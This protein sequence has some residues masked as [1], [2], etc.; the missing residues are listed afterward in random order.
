MDR[1]VRNQQ[2]QA[3]AVVGDLLVHA[4]WEPF[5]DC[6]KR[7][8]GIHGN[9]GWRVGQWCPENVGTWNSLDFLKTHCLRTHWITFVIEM[10][11]RTFPSKKSFKKQHG[12]WSLPRWLAGLH[13]ADRWKSY[14]FLTGAKPASGKV[15]TG[16]NSDVCDEC[17]L[18]RPKNQFS[19]IPHHV[20][21]WE[22]GCL[23][24]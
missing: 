2:G 22:K 21:I 6:R 1:F 8:T 7:P 9:R 4:Q 20:P 17:W 23:N 3:V 14:N 11:F 13:R 12:S 24:E 10:N 18:K 15:G 5:A 16:L 19:R